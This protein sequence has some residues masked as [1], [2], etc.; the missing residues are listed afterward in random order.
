MFAALVWAGIFNLAT[1]LWFDIPIAVQPMHTISAVAVSQGFSGA[2]IAGA[3]MFVASVALGLG[4]FNLIHRIERYVNQLTS[5]CLIP[6]CEPSRWI[7][8]AVVKGIQLGLGLGL[9][10]KGLTDKKYGAYVHSQEHQRVWTGADSIATSIV[11][12]AFI[13]LTY[14]SPRCP[15]ALL[16]FIYGIIFAATKSHS[17]LSFGVHIPLVQPSLHDFAEGTLQAGLPQLPLTLLNSVVALSL[18]AR[19]L[20]P[21]REAV[22]ARRACISLGASNLVNK[23]A[24]QSC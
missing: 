15:T 23:L 7:P 14:K 20:Y 4:A 13:I 16:L 24:F 9:I 18:L 10:V 11:F 17:A 5:H 6:D 22:G 2:E 21:R 19:E 8:L 1:V 12:A 3:G